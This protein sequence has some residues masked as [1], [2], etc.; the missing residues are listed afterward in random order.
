[1]HYLQ[2]RSCCRVP[3][4][5][6]VMTRCVY[7]LQLNTD[8]HNMHSNIRL[9]GLRVSVT[10]FH[11]PAPTCIHP[12]SS[13]GLS[14]W[15]LLC[16][17]PIAAVMPRAYQR[18]LCCYTRSLSRLLCCYTRSLSRLLCCY[19]RSLSRLLCCYTRSLSRLLYKELITAV[20]P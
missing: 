19:T 17:E 6:E 7:R 8:E 15:M 12:P 13:E 10:V 1:M 4:A 2:V 14:R 20:V 5:Q 3:R 16:Q 9:R 18:L 11:Y